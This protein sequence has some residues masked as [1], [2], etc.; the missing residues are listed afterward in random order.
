MEK[1]RNIPRQERMLLD[2]EE[3]IRSQKEEDIKRISSELKVVYN[4]NIY[5]VRRS[6]LNEIISRIAKKWEVVVSFSSIVCEE[7]RKEEVQSMCL[8]LGL[9]GSPRWIKDSDFSEKQKE[10]LTQCN[11]EWISRAIYLRPSSRVMS[12]MWLYDYV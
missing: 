2:L 4:P 11:I 9:K 5:G 10:L 12:K 6:I 3:W 1:F 8:N 7:K